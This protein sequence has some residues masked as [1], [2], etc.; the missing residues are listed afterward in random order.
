M[1]LLHARRACALML[2]ALPLLL[3]P[4][5]AGAAQP[6]PN[7]PIRMIVA[8]PPGGPPGGDFDFSGFGLVVSREYAL[9]LQRD[10]PLGALGPVSRRVPPRHRAPLARRCDQR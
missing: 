7:K 9:T 5:D 3:P 1:S 6:F 10:Q 4:A 8:V 2:A